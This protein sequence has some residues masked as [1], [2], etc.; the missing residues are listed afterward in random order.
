MNPEPEYQ[1]TPPSK[2]GSWEFRGEIRAINSTTPLAEWT[3]IEVRP[4]EQDG[5]IFTNLL[6]G[7]N[8]DRKTHISNYHGQWRE[9]IATSDPSEGYRLLGTD[10]PLQEGDEMA[11]G[12][13]ANPRWELVHRCMW[14]KPCDDRAM[15]RPVDRTQDELTKLRA[16]KAA[17]KRA[18][19][20]MDK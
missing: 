17:V 10:E 2:A 9:P 5:E 11:K 1:T 12:W 4:Y 16:F 20:E 13:K 15:R 6:M 3:R 18:M 14:G 7:H 19:E 8:L